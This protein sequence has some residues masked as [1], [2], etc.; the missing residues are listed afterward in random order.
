MSKEN[1]PLPKP[2][3][4]L[5]YSDKT[6]PT[7]PINESVKK[8]A[9]A[10]PTQPIIA[11]VQLEQPKQIEVAS[12][13]LSG[14]ETKIITEPVTEFA[15]S[16]NPVSIGKRPHADDIRIIGG[17]GYDVRQPVPIK[18]PDVRQHFLS[19]RENFWTP[20]E[21]SM[22]AD[23]AQWNTGSLSEEEL[24]LFKCNI[25]YLTASDN[26]VPDNLD[27]AILENIT[28]NEM[29]QYLR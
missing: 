22:G 4:P 11:P 17:K 8:S 10:P 2:Y 13:N 28:A 16:L 15:S 27:N 14:I 18:Y 6:K 7:Q 20:Q 23:K 24:W 26:L 1:Q 5:Q 12:D 3:S 19:S 25:S 29:R 9:I 21:I